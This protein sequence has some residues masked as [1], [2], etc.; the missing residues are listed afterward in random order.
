MKPDAPKTSLIPNPQQLQAYKEVDEQLPIII[1]KLA[2]IE[3]DHRYWHAMWGMISAVVLAVLVFG[4]FTFL[5]MHNHPTD[6]KWLLGV[7]ILNLISGF[8][9]NRLESGRAGRR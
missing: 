3:S 5:V 8:Y 9:K 2:R 7:G 1:I 4:G 6:A